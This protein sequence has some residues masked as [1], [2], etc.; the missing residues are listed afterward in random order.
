MWMTK[1]N[2]HSESQLLGGLL[3]GRNVWGLYM[4]APP[5]RLAWRELQGVFFSVCGLLAEKEWLTLAR[6]QEMNSWSYMKKKA[7]SVWGR[8]WRRG[9]AANNVTQMYRA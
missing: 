1:N 7:A 6:G 3:G 8:T 4:L 2:H 9:E 5:A